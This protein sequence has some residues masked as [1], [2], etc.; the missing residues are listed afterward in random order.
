MCLSLTCNSKLSE[1]SPI[2]LDLFPRELFLHHLD[3][4]YRVVNL[5]HK[6]LGKV[7]KLEVSVSHSRPLPG[8]VHLHDDLQ[9]CRLTRTIFSHNTDPRLHSGGQIDVG[10]N[11][12]A[13]FVVSVGHLAQ[14][15]DCPRHLLHLGKLQSDPR[16]NNDWL[17]N[18]KPL[19]GFDAGLDECGSFGIVPET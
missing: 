6:V 1:H 5:V 8:I 9:K 17:Q 4:T 7:A 16:L 3:W 10:E 18:W 14:C 2:L 12:S 19:Q 15:Q 11:D 13:F